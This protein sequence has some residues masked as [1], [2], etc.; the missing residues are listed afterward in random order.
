MQLRAGLGAAEGLGRAWEGHAR[1][2]VRRGEGGAG[3]TRTCSGPEAPEEAAPRR[4]AAAAAAAA[5]H[6]RLMTRSIFGGE[7]GAVEE[8]VWRGAAKER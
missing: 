1:I 2:G 4:V 5:T 6:A 3:G 7:G 8:C